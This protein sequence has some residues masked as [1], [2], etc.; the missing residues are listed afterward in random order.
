MTQTQILAQ[1]EQAI[2]AFLKRLLRRKESENIGKILLY[3]SM[4]WGKPREESDVDLYIFSKTPQ[5]IDKMATDISTDILL[6]TGE[7]IEPMV[8]SLRDYYNPESGLLI[9]AIRE[10]KELYSNQRIL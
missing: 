7:I 1:K 6:Q 4:I 3:G 2:G 9:K 10:G 5:K 8:K